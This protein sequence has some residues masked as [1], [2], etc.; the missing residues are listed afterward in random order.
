MTNKILCDT[1]FFIALLIQEDSN[2]EKAMAITHSH[3]DHIFTYSNLTKYELVT[4]LSRKLPQKIAIQA[5]ELFEDAFEDRFD[6]DVQLEDKVLDFYKKSLNKN[7]SFFD[8]ACLVQAQKY[9]WKIASFD[10]FYPKTL[11]VTIQ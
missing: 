8:A 3:S 7:I 11:L 1:D 6:F 5:L 4:V 2:H 9:H 10:K